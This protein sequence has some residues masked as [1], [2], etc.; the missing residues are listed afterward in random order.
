MRKNYEKPMFAVEEY[1]L[2]QNIASCMTKIGLA[3][4]DCVLK[5]DDAT[6]QMKDFAMA[7]YFAGTKVCS[8]S[9]E[10]MDGFDGICYHTNANAA[11]SS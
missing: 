9:S 4:S 2:T 1:A 10:D 5:D 3:S 11:F 7:G 8:V 6:S